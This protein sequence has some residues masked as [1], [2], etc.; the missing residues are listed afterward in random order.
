MAKLPANFE[1]RKERAEYIL[2]EMN[3]KESVEADG[4]PFL[5]FSDFYSI[6][7]VETSIGTKC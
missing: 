2:N 3:E 5:N 7:K 6:K 1:A 4:E